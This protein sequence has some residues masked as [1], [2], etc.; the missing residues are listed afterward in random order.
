MGGQGQDA[1]ATGEHGQATR[2]PQGPD[3]VG[4]GRILWEFG[5]AAPD[6]S[7]PLFYDGRLYVFDGLKRKTIT[8]LEPRTGRVFWQG[9]VGGRSRWWSSP[10][11][12]DG[13]IYLISEA[14]EIIVFQAGGDEFKVLLET[15][16]KEPPIQSSI[17][18][19]AGH[20]FIRTAEHLYCI[21]K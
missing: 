14:G 21:G 11:A 3:A 18:I 2:E 1:L 10:T 13:R 12:A 17:A 7:T 5:E 4:T 6:C 15:Q 20:L 8:C 16:I 9:K 19:A